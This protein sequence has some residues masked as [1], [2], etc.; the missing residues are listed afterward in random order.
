MEQTSK[1]A[2]FESIKIRHTEHKGESWFSVV[3]VIAAL[4][5]SS[6]PKRYWSDMKKTGFKRV[7]SVVRILRTTENGCRRW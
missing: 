2:L 3:D 7:K 4:T 6:Q 5:D 1:I